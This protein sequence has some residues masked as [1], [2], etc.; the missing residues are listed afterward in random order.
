METVALL[1][2]PYLYISIGRESMTGNTDRS[3]RPSFPFS[4][5]CFKD[6]LE[7]TRHFS[8]TPVISLVSRDNLNVVGINSSGLS[9]RM[10]LGSFCKAMNCER[11]F[12]FMFFRRTCPPLP[13]QEPADECGVET[14]DPPNRE[15]REVGC[16]ERQLGEP[17][18]DEELV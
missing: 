1:C 14:D 9:I 17:F 4:A 7:N 5:T 18:D 3:R 8:L 6:N 13:P 11:R 10:P 15:W 12:L 16:G 2:G